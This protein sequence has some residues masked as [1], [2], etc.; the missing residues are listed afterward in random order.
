MSGSVRAASSS[1]AD[2]A[3]SGL[4]GWSEHA[5]AI[6]ARGRPRIPEGER[7]EMTREQWLARV[8]TVELRLARRVDVTE[9]RLAALEQRF[10]SWPGG[11]DEAR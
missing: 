10:A 6:L 4:A 8:A 1:G 9:Q 3:A 7:V 11:A 5:R 2:V